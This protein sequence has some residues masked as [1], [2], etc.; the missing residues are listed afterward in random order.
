MNC[1]CLLKSK[2]SVQQYKV[3]ISFFVGI[4]EGAVGGN[5]RES[6]GNYEWV[7]RLLQEL[8]RGQDLI[9]ILDSKLNQWNSKVNELN[10]RMGQV[11]TKMTEVNKKVTQLKLKIK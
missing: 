1:I 2:I 7:D 11:E 6:E 8:I 9:N 5:D 10:S 4:E 3:A